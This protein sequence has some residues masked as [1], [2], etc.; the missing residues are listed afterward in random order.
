MRIAICGGTGVLGRHVVAEARSRGWEVASLSRSS[1]VDLVT[2]DGLDAALHGAEA[3]IDVTN[4]MTVRRGPA[5][6]FFEATARNLQAAARREGVPHLV[7]V[8]IVGV[9][10]MGGFGY[11]GAKVTQERLHLDG[12]VD[13]TVLR[14]TQFHEFPGQILSRSTLGPVAIVPGLRVQTVAARAVAA[15]LIEAT[16]AGPFRGRLPDVAG[17]GPAR[18]LPALARVVLERQGRRSTVLALRV[19]GAMGRAV[20]DGAL[21][22][23][24]DG[25]LT[26]PTFEEWLM[27]PDGPTS[28]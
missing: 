24:A 21:L 16:A 10:R 17:P 14:A 20:R 2:G 15:A 19:P 4:V 8:S 27:G 23:A 5:V 13:T 7:V 6:R 1:G 25:A 9:D 22:P 18:H 12:P 28:P 3:A 11:Y 26:G